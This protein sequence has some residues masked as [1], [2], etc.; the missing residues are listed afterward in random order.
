MNIK[1]DLI[2]KR[3]GSILDEENVYGKWEKTLK[4]KRVLKPRCKC[5]TND[6]S[7]LKCCEI[8]EDDRKVIYEKFWGDDLGRKE[9]FRK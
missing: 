2:G 5:K 7:A 4:N 9:D 8:T 6:K 3:G 1:T